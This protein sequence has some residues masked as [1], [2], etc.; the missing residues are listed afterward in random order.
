MGTNNPYLPS[1][2]LSDE[3]AIQYFALMIN[4]LKNTTYITKTGAGPFTL[5]ATETVGGVIEFSGSTTAVVVNTPTA[6]AIIARMQALDANAAV[7]S[8]FNLAII[9][10]NT[11][12]GAITMTAGDGN[13]TFV[14]GPAS[15]AV[16]AIAT[17]KKYLVKWAT[18]TTVTFAAIV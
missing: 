16:V 6:A 9:N 5:T 7:G 12:S 4:A 1:N 2:V 13:V 8:T 14:A 15:P 11:S 17:M 3:E 18:T 10:D